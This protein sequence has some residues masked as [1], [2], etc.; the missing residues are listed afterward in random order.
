[1]HNMNLSNPSRISHAVSIKPLFSSLNTGIPPNLNNKYF[2]NHPSGQGIP[3][4]SRFL[5]KCIGLGNREKIHFAPK[6]FTCKSRDK[7]ASNPNH[8]SLY[9]VCG[10]PINTIL[11]IFGMS[12]IIFH[13]CFFN[14]YLANGPSI[15]RLFFG[16]LSG[17]S[18]I[19]MAIFSNEFI[20]SLIITFHVI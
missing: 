14:K 4:L 19:C 3:C 8:A 12:P 16:K 6:N 7:I 1:M 2:C 13:F 11:L 5:E 9:A 10:A 18:F 15:L 20:H 17:I